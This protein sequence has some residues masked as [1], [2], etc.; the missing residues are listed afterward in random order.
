MQ[1]VKRTLSVK[2]P[3]ENQILPA[4]VPVVR[5]IVTGLIIVVISLMLILGLYLLQRSDPY[6]QSVLTTKGDRSRGQAMFSI[7]CAGCHGINGDGMIGPSL[8]EVSRRKSS[9]DL[10]RQVTSGKTPPMPRFQPN[11]QE[12][13]DLL[14]FL[15]QL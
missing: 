10:I 7:N 14:S 6:I 15:E 4:K 11:S 1:N 9:I 3:V 13:A 2:L 12:M 5:I 8:H